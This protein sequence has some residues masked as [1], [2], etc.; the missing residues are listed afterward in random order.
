MEWKNSR[1]R[2]GEEWWFWLWR[3]R[4]WRVGG[5]WTWCLDFAEMDVHGVRSGALLGDPVLM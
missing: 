1:V 2:V 3:Q 4:F 5:R